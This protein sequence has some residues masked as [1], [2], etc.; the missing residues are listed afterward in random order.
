VRAAEERLLAGEEPPPLPG[1]H[2]DPYHC[3]GVVFTGLPH[4]SVWKVVV[5]DDP[6]YAPTGPA[7]P[8]RLLPGA[9]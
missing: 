8:L 6:L 4:G 2:A 3:G 1:T 5:E 7:P 9:A